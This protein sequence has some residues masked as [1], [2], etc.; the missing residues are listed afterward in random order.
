LSY[1]A[2]APDS[3]AANCYYTADGKNG[4]ADFAAIPG[5]KARS[6]TAG[7]GAVLSFGQFTAYSVSGLSGYPAG[8]AYSGAFYAGEG[9]I[10]SLNLALADG[11][12]MPEDCV[13]GGFVSSAGILKR[14]GQGWSLTMPDA[15]VMIDALFAPVF[16]ETDF[17]LPG[18]LE[19]IEAE[20]F[21]NAAMTALVI[22]A[23]C[24]SIGD[25][26]FRCCQYLSQVRIP[27]GCVLGEDVFDMCELVYVYGVPGSPAEDY[28]A[29]HGNC[30]FVEE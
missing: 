9:D 1:R 4:S 25:H 24:S 15:S 20:A 3:R 14:S 10:L 29:V 18:S 13:F 11:I 2:L 5:S 17:A 30:V 8:L 22:P 19:A 16:G 28:C 12:E 26:A 7:E 6:V 27:A 23:S 21:E